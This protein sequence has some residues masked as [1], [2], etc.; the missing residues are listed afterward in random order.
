MMRG[1]GFSF[2]VALACYLAKGNTN[3]F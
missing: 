3:G 1:A 2:L